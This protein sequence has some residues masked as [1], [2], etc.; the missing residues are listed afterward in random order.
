[1]KEEFVTHE[2]SKKLKEKGFPLVDYIPTINQAMKWLREEHK[3]YLSPCTITDY[4]DDYHHSNIVYWSFIVVSI[5]SGDSIYR[6]YEKLTENRYDS[7]E[8]S[9]I[10]GI[11]YVIDNLI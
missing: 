3:L 7:Y 4:E 2:I 1:M 9:A 8:S 11:K 6:E 10:G 5:E